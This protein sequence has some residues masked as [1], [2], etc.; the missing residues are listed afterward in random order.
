MATFGNSKMTSN[1]TTATVVYKSLQNARN[2][3]GMMLAKGKH[4]GWFSDL[5]N[6]PSDLNIHLQMNRFHRR[7]QSAMNASSH[8]SVSLHMLQTP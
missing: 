8:C 6:V 5:A 1:Q 3:D 2:N 7:T 4:H